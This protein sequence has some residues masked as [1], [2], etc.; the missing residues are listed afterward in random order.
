MERCRLRH[1]EDTGTIKALIREA[2]QAGEAA[3]RGSMVMRKRVARVGA[4]LALESS[5]EGAGEYLGSKAAG[6]EA[7]FTEAA[8]EALM[9]MPGCQ[10][11]L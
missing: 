10:S 3:Y 9:S 6:V 8:L 11:V 7:S 2:T 1:T 4:N 5:G